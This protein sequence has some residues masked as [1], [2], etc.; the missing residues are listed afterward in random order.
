MQS[1]FAACGWSRVM[2][3]RLR[4]ILSAEQSIKGAR[5]FILDSRFQ[6]ISSIGR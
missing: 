6:Q 3:L 5:V 1:V 2:A 4:L